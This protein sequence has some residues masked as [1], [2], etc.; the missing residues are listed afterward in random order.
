[1][2][3]S[4][5]Q[6]KIGGII[7]YL[8]IGFSI[9]SGLIYTPWMISVIGQSNFGLYTL[10]TSLVTMVTVDLGLSSAVT[11]FISKYRAEN[12]I[13]SIKKF[14][15]IVYKLFIALAFLFFI[16]LTIVYFNIDRI[17]LKLNHDEIQT[18][19][20][21]LSIAGLYA[22]FSFPFHPLDGLLIS[23]EWFVFQKSTQLITKVLNVLLMVIALLMGYGLYSLVV[24]NAF[25]GIIVIG[26]KLFFLRKK[27]PQEI[28][29]KTFDLQMTKEIFSFSLWVMVI[30]IAQRLIMNI[31]PSILGVTSGSREIA[32]FSAAMTIEGYVWTFATVFSGMFL[33]KVS[34]MI[35]GEKAGSA[36]IQELMIKV[37]RVQYILLAGIV[38]IYI[39][40][41]REFFLKWLGPE[42][43]KSYFI[44]VLLILPGL[45]TIPQEIASTAL[46]ASNKV[47]YNA[48]SR[49]I[50]AIISISLSYIFSLK[51]GSTGAGIA[52]LIGNLVG[53]AVVLNIIYSRILKIK[54]WEFFK[55]CQ[56][57]MSLPF[58]LVLVTGLIL[59]YLFIE[60]SWLN[61]IVKIII[62][63]A[64]YSVSAYYF[65]INKYEKELIYS[66]V[67]KIMRN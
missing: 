3:N 29:W 64:I 13:E 67:K 11:R 9:V 51:F 30:S 12:D 17:F 41:G 57:D 36:A 45:I 62:L 35:Y 63:L 60:L 39:V 61:I 4:S 43:E 37:G 53:G 32:I 2:Q 58:V 26:L 52:I 42:F 25:C 6:I 54:V 24:V 5:K 49:I 19:K 55:K 16:S 59:N 10:A 44:A 18:V 15:G 46:I 33:P 65:S 34:K 31:T 50:I 27:D 66:F 40:V 21:L 8:T 47:R 38:S 28:A 23:G 14:L 56:L 20:V 7:S 1:M 22:V 48:F